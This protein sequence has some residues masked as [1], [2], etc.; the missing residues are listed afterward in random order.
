[1]TGTVV[2]QG[3]SL[4]LLRVQHRA[5]GE[6]LAP[7]MTQ[8]ETGGAGGAPWGDFFG[9]DVPFLGFLWHKQER[10]P[11]PASRARDGAGRVQA[12]CGGPR[13]PPGALAGILV[14][15]DPLGRGPDTRGLRLRTRAQLGAFPARPRAQ[16]LER[17]RE[18][19]AGREISPE[20]VMSAAPDGWGAAGA[21]HGPVLATR[22]V[23][24]APAGAG[25]DSIPGCHDLRLLSSWVGFGQFLAPPSR[26]G[27]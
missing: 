22:R 18:A 3:A 1:M 24:R 11:P 23:R 27:L 6:L 15:Q 19:A 4:S 25:C 10:D 5:V 7:S 9:N 12:G 14:A 13:S 21:W 2:A 16:R 17:K 8:G 26:P 20:A